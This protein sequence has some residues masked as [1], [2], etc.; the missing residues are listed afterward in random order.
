MSRPLPERS[1]Y[2]E[3]HIFMRGVPQYLAHVSI[4]KFF[5][6]FNPTSRKICHP[7]NTHTTIV[8]GFESGSDARR[9]IEATTNRVIDDY[10]IRVELYTVW[11]SV[12][13]LRETAAQH[14]R[15]TAGFLD[16]KSHRTE[17]GGNAT[18]P[19]ALTTNNTEVK[20]IGELG[21]LSTPKLSDLGRQYPSWA[22]M[23]ANDEM[24]P[25]LTAPDLSHSDG[26]DSPASINDSPIST[27]HV[28]TA[29]PI[30]TLANGA[31][32][33]L[34]RC[35]TQ[36]NEATLMLAKQVR[37]K[38]VAWIT[39]QAQTAQAPQKDSTPASGNS[40]ILCNTIQREDKIIP[41]S[42]FGPR[43]Y[44]YT[45]G[46]FESED[47]T[48]RLS[49]LELDDSP[50]EEEVPTTRTKGKGELVSAPDSEDE[51]YWIMSKYCALESK[52][53]SSSD[54]RLA[55]PTRWKTISIADDQQPDHIPVAPRTSGFNL[56]PFRGW[57]HMDLTERVRYRHRCVCSFCQLKAR[58]S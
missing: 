51:D 19:P 8:F 13:Y 30:H 3:R 1:K 22:R 27:P 53:R 4:P 57:Q 41:A 24:K 43:N 5:D 25:P 17:R 10:R 7:M 48:A 28:T 6:K 23:V 36:L 54:L 58:C 50:S 52:M 14:K 39:P 18:P 38:P 55:S 35:S 29:T 42:A 34:R 49:N 56:I 45:S 20:E 37:P 26:R 44:A 46:V 16:P 21:P 11:K 2:N 31:K 33:E 47:S 9:A 32:A 40:P 15:R 12:R